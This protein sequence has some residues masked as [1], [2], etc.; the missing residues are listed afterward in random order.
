MQGK[1]L[2]EQSVHAN[3]LMGKFRKRFKKSMILGINN[4]VEMAYRK[5]PF[6]STCTALGLHKLKGQHMNHH[7]SLSVNRSTT[8]L[9]ETRYT[10]ASL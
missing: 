4:N 1:G 7:G 10:F 9:S 3:A 6:Y 8:Q 2:K 5:V